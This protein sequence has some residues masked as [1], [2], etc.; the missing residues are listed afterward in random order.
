MVVCWCVLDSNSS[1]GSLLTLPLGLPSAAN[2]P[3]L[4]H[5]DSEQADL[6]FET[7]SINTLS[8]RFGM[9]LCLSFPTYKTGLCEGEVTCEKPQVHRLVPVE[10]DNLLLGAV[11]ME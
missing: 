11:D 9:F 5:P 3:R 6:N 2:L 7:G 10:T 8:E 1:T 4:C